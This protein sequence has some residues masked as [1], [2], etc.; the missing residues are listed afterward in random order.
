MLARETRR[1]EDRGPERRYLTDGGTPG[2][3]I[4]DRVSFGA[5]NNEIGVVN[6]DTGN[7][8]ATTGQN[9]IDVRLD[10]THETVS[11]DARDYCE[12]DHGTQDISA[13]IAQRRP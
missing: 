12:W 9:V 4:G 6:G 3:A 1:S 2:L 13:E 7:V 10:R 5:N 11:F 8:I